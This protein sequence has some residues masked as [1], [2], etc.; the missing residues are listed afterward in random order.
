[1]LA[2]LRDAGELD[3]TYVIFTSDNGFMHGEHRI[4]MGKIH[5]YDESSRVP[6]LLRGPG[7]P[8]GATANGL[9]TNA[10]LAPT[11]L[12]VADVAPGLP[13]D[14]I[15][16]LE[17][18]GA[19]DRSRELLIENHLDNPS[20]GWTAY[21]AVRTARYLY[22]EYATGERELFDVQTDPHQLDS[23]HADPA[24][25]RV[26]DWM[27]RRLAELRTCQGDS[28]RETVVN[29]PPAAPRAA[30][31]RGRMATLTGSPGSDNLVGTRG[32]DVIAALGGDDTILALAGRDL[33]CAGGGGDFVGAGSAADRVFGNAGLDVLLGRGG[34]DLLKGS[35]GNDVLMGNRGNDRLRGGRANDRCRGGLGLD[36]LR[37]CER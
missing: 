6:L 22:I 10:D 14:G 27:A 15:S 29:A 8:A 35:R 33:V 9:A 2:A 7:V 32:K 11:I 20:L 13:Q 21:T 25:R 5:A 26:V 12:D 36:S 24:Y 1:M 3:H 23:R 30:S 31:C 37:G 19:G 18:I 16:L 17:V 4:P 28:C 34:S